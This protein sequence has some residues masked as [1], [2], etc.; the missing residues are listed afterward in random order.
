LAGGGLM[1]F[2]APLTG[3]MAG[4]LFFGDRELD[5]SIS[6][7]VKGGGGVHYEGTIYFPT[8]D[9]FFAG[10]GKG[11]SSSPYSFFIARRFAFVGNG[12][13]DINSNYEASTVPIPPRVGPERPGLVR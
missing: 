2:S 7:T 8:T 11:S 6:H 5:S 4:I 13:I 12:N 3:P 10:N 1:T 9:V